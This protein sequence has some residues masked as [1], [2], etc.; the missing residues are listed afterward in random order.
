MRRVRIEQDATGRL[1]AVDADSREPIAGV[2]RIEISN[3]AEQ[4][5]ARVSLCLDMDEVDLAFATTA[6]IFV[7]PIPHPASMYGRSK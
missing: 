1:R 4:G 3:G 5:R 6:E 7:H 2:W